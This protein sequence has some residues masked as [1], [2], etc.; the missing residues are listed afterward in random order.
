MRIENVYSERNV[1][2]ANDGGHDVEGLLR[3]NAELLGE[4]RSLKG[5]IGEIERE[6]DEALQAAE[7]AKDAMLRLQLEEPVE[8]ALSGAFVA[9]WRVMRPLL[10]EHLEFALTEEGRPE[11]KVRSSGEVLP[12]DGLMGFVATIPDLAAAL[13]PP[14]GGGARS[15]GEDSGGVAPRK[16]EHRPVARQF[17]LR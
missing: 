16:P 7:T 14:S 2:M 11:I 1:V 4:V 13:K 10:D 9:P 8:Q 12:Q 6:R 17:G 5:R 3:K 15:V